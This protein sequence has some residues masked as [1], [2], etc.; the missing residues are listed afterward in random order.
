MSSEINK[1]LCAILTAT[2]FFLLASFLSE[3]IY[4]P[5]DSNGKVSYLVEIENISEKVP[6]ENE[7]IKIDKITNAQLAASINDYDEELGKKFI[8]KNCAACHEFKLPHK[9]KIG[10]SLALLFNRK[11]GSLDGYRYSKAFKEVQGD[12][13][14]INLYNFLQKPKEWVPGT[15]MSYKGIKN[16]ND[17]KNVLKYLAYNKNNGN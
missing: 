2:L 5:Y 3:L 1:L 12:W 9:N 17:L 8:T 11:I 4:P 16:E 14:L 10:P 7:N 6:T 13:N 15:K